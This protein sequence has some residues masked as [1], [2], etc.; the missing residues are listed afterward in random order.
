[1]IRKADVMIETLAPGAIERWA[2]P[3]TSVKAINP[4][5]STPSQGFGEGSRRAQPRLRHD[6]PGVRRTFS[7][8]ETERPADRPHLAVIP[9]RHADGDHDRGRAV[10][11]R[12]TARAIACR[13]PC[14]TRCCTTCAST[15]ATQGL[16]GSGPE[17]G[18]QQGARVSNAPMGCIRARR[19]G[20]RYVYSMTSRANP[21]H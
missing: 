1:M 13:S 10:Q 3:M 2:C 20:R 12:E 5:S 8:T 19:A 18:G 14:R 7:V 15:L 11:A 9:A 16:T 21:G 4:R 17:R 6:C